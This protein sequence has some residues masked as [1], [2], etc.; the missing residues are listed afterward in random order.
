MSV[1]AQLLGLAMSLF[2]VLWSGVRWLTKTRAGSAGLAGV[3]AFSIGWLWGDFHGVSETRKAWRQSNIEA[4]QRLAKRD[5]EIAEKTAAK[6][7][8]TILN[9]E[10]QVAA[11][12]SKLKDPDASCLDDP[13]VKRLL[14]IR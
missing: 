9:L 10:Q 6:F 11:Y 2:N 8:P 12:A 7:K 3:V 14:R 13:A 1:V 4:S 5:T